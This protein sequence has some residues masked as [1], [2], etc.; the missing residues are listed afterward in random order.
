MCSAPRSFERAVEENVQNLFTEAIGSGS[1]GPCQMAIFDVCKALL[2]ARRIG[3]S[4][5]PREEKPALALRPGLVACLD[6]SHV[7]RS[8]RPDG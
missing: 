6:S 3:A 4:L 8:G 5:A 2:T 1:R 7:A